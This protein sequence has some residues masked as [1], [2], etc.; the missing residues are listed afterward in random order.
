MG[1]GGRIGA[2]SAAFG[3]FCTSICEISTAGDIAETGTMPDSAPHMPLNT[4]I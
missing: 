4:A 3:F 1:G 2:R